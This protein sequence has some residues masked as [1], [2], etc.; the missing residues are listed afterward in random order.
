MPTCLVISYYFPPMAGGGVQRAMSFVR[1]LPEHGWT[2][3]VATSE[4]VPW[5]AYDSSL[6][7]KLGERK[8]AIHR[9]SDLPLPSPFRRVRE[10][11][12]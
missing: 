8:P 4:G 5:P 11:R 12:A 2:P 1:H 3:I 10:S 9:V 7:Q 6:L